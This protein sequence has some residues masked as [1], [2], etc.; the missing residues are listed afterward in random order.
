MG[1]SSSTPKKVTVEMDQETGT[2]KISEAVVRRMMGEEEPKGSVEQTGSQKTSTAVDLERD[3]E[4]QKQ[5]KL[6]EGQWKEKLRQAELKNAELYRM[7]SEQFTKAAEDVESKFI[8]QS[9]QPVCKDLQEEVLKCY[10]INPRET[11]NCEAE[12]RAFTNCV[13]LTRNSVLTKREI[14]GKS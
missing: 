11:L 13:D 3:E 7:T 6:S 8:H 9:Y 10:T 5:L 2:V 12:V 1:G 4:F 14:P